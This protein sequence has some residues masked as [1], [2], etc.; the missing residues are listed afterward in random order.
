MEKMKAH[1]FRATT[2]RMRKDIHSR[3]KIFPFTLNSPI[4]PFSFLCHL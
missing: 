1:F 3:K 4:P 2:E